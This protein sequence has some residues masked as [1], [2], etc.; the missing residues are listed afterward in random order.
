[1]QPFIHIQRQLSEHAAWMIRKRPQA[2]RTMFFVEKLG[3]ADDGG[4]GGLVAA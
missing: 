1:M 3:E 2:L 4:F